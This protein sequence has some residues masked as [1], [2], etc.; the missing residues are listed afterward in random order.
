MTRGEGDSAVPRPSSPRVRAKR[1]RPGDCRPG[2][3][4][5]A[6][7]THLTDLPAIFPEMSLYGCFEVVEEARASGYS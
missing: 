1:N 6:G 4:I 7:A 5:K 3:T 2:D